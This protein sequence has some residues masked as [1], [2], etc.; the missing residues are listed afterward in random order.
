MLL[1]KTTKVLDIHHNLEEVN[2]THIFQ[3]IDDEMRTTCQVTVTHDDWV[4][5][6]EPHVLTVSVQ[7]GDRLNDV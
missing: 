7:A 5:L 2:G 6:G 1:S 4:D 3:Q